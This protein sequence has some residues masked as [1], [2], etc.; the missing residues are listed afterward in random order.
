MPGDDEPTVKVTLHTIYEEQLRQRLDMVEL[1]GMLERMSDRTNAVESSMERHD[2]E[3]DWL[4]K[5]ALT[6]KGAMMVAAVGGFLVAAATLL[7][8]A[9]SQ[10]WV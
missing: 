8:R 5:N 7:I 2:Q 4:Q 1:K 9:A 10:T 3:I 6:R